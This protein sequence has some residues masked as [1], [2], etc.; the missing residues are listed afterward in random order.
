M[1]IIEENN[2]SIA[3]ARA[4][5]HSMESPGGEINPLIVIVNGFD[6]GIIEENSGIRDILDSTL[7]KKDLSCIETVSNTIFPNSLWNMKRG[8]KVLFNRYNKTWELIKKHQPNR[9]GTYFNRMIAYDCAEK[10]VN[11]LEHIINTWHGG[12]HRHSALQ[13]SIFD[14]RKDH[15]NNRV[16]GFP[17]LQQVDINPLGTKG[18]DGLCITGFYATQYLLEKA[19]GN[20]LGI[21][22]LGQFMAKEMKLELKKVIYFA[23]LS[24]LGNTTKSALKDLYTKIKAVL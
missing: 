13:A 5:L 3:W 6:D 4:F 1:K 24:K 14:P 8:R 7:I 11:Q 17:C 21:A 22:R 18:K 20:Y 2:L 16:L 15:N 10:P 9:R 12:N 23:S 19:Y